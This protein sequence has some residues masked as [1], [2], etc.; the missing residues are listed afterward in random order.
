MIIAVI[1][2]RMVEAAVDEIVEMVAMRHRFMSAVRTVDMRAVNLRRALLGIFRAHRDDM[3]VH[4][5]L[6]H[7]VEMAIVKIIHMAVMA[8]GR[9]T[10]S[11]AVLVGMVAVL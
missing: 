11:R 2:M 5:I 6:V 9:V 4:V 7:M 3:F 8:D 1:T 10:A